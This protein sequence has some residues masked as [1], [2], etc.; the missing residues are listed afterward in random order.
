MSEKNLPEIYLAENRINGK[1]YVG[2]TRRGVNARWT[3]HKYL[4]RT[5]PKSYFHRALAKY[6]ADNFSVAHIATAIASEYAFELERQLIQQY[7][8][9]YNLTNGGESTMGRRVPKEIYAVIAAKNRGK[10]RT[11]EMNA[12]NSA[13]K[14]QQLAT[15]PEYLQKALA[16][17]E[18]GRNNLD[19][20]E[21]QR[22]AV[23]KAGTGRKWTAE[24]RAKFIA[25]RTGMPIR[26]TEAVIA[27][28]ER[29]KR[30]VECI[31]LN[32]VFD[33]VIEA[34]EMTGVHFSHISKVCR[35]ERKRAGGLE[36]IFCNSAE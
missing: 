11:P 27:S 34:G 32:T 30:P 23:I 16:A 13:R 29:K 15:N 6:G 24:A 8:P 7:S 25:A 9:E 33:S 20:K 28:N 36:F 35:G 26:K 31:T 1:A 21:N 4:A 2:L 22:L 17:L 19:R 18:K 14:K 3:Q 5:N 10:K 12:A